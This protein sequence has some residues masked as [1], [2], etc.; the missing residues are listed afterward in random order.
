MHPAPPPAAHQRADPN[1]PLD[2]KFSLQYVMARALQY[3]VLRLKHFEGEAYVEP[4]IIA[5]W[6]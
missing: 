1:S 2:A 3:G 4:E 6:T 5:C